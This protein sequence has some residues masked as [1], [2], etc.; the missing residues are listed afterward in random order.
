MS[1][2]AHSYLMYGIIIEWKGSEI[3]IETLFNYN[4]DYERSGDSR[5]EFFDLVIGKRLGQ[6]DEY[7]ATTINMFDAHLNT[8]GV[9]ELFDKFF[10]D[11][12]ELKTELSYI[13][14]CCIK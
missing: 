13:M 11:Y 6:S 4:L 14:V 8:V 2:T 12:P 7:C 3:D 1:Y 9:K 5:G 10:E